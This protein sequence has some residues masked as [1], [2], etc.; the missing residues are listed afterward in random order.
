M[1][2]S[3]DRVPELI[4]TAIAVSGNENLDIIVVSMNNASPDYSKWVELQTIEKDQTDAYYNMDAFSG[5]TPVAHERVAHMHDY[6]DG[7]QASK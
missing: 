6:L 5:S 1:I 7:G 4:E 2:T 3:D